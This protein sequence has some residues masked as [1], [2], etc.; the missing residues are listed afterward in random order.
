VDALKEKQFS[1]EFPGYGPNSKPALV[2]L[3]LEHHGSWSQGTIAYWD[4]QIKTAHD[5]EVIN[6][7]YLTLL[8]V[9][10]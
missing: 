9:L 8:S 4:A 10:V 5:R 1:T 6:M 7:E 3:S 2:I